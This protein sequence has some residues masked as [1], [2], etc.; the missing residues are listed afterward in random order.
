MTY[1]KNKS[2]WFWGFI[3]LLL[4]NVSIMGSLMY[5]MQRIHHQP[6]YNGFH[7]HF[8]PKKKAKK[9]S[10]TKCFV[11]GLEINPKQQEA[12][13]K[14]RQVHFKE[15][16]S[17]KRTLRKKQHDL[18]LETSKDNP[19]SIVVI[20]LRKDNIKLHEQIMDE[21]LEFFKKMQENLTP[22]QQDIMKKHYLR[23]LNNNTQ[24][25]K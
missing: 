16:K 8:V 4:I 19:D 7:R 5:A 9:H 18:F 17:L 14:M 21:S 13:D 1:F 3:I 15:M 2:I 11:K 12:L 6:D 25:R 10:K 20:Q 24:N 23:K 22:D